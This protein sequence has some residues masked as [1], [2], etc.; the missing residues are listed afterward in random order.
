MPEHEDQY[1]YD[2]RMSRVLRKRLDYVSNIDKKHVSICFDMQYYDMYE[3]PFSHRYKSFKLPKHVDGADE[4][5][6]RLVQNNEPYVLYHTK[7]SG[8]PNGMPVD[9][10]NFRAFHR[11]PNIKL[12]NVDQA[13]DQGNILKWV[14]LIAHATEIHVVNGA[15]WNLVESMLDYTKAQLYFHDIRHPVVRVNH[16]WNNHRWNVVKYD[17]RIVEPSMLHPN[18][19]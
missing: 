7:T 4:L 5:Y 2:N 19:R 16:E 9:I 11:F 18:D 6:N 8:F 15:F 13:L 17:N 12:I 1:V 3:I 14:K 10:P